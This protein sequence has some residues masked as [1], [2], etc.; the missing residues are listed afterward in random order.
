MINY[1]NN[2][3]YNNKIGIFINIK[4]KQNK[5]ENKIKSYFKIS[6]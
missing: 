5:T 3:K 2:N 1:R 4:Q 6:Y